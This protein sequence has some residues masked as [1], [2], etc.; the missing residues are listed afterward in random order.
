MMGSPQDLHELLTLC[1]QRGVRPI[2]DSAFG[3]GEV[4][5]AFAKLASGDVFGKIVVDHTR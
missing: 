3:F 4:R 1:A 5:D 2:V